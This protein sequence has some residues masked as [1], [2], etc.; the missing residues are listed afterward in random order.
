MIEKDSAGWER[1]LIKIN[2]GD[3]DWV[4]GCKTMHR[5]PSHPYKAKA[6][7]NSN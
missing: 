2:F 3:L 4:Q 6:G 7:H 5:Y 1:L